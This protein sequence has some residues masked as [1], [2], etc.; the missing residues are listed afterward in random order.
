MRV[1]GAID[2]V[3]LIK[4]EVGTHP[5]PVSPGVNPITQKINNRLE[6]LIGL[7]IQ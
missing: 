4:G 6:R 1:Q 5:R 7:P 2:V 3:I